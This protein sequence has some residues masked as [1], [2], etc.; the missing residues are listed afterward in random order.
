L[1]LPK[2]HIIN[3]R[4]VEIFEQCGIGDR[5]RALGSKHEYMSQVAWMTSLA[6]PT[7][8]HGR[9]LARSDSWGGGEDLPA[10]LAASPFTHTNLPQIRLEPILHERARELAPDDILIEH[11]LDQ[12]EQQ[13]G[14]V[15]ATVTDLKTGDP[16]QVV[17]DYVVAA[18]GGRTIGRI[19]GIEDVGQTNLV[20]MIT[21]YLRSPGIPQVNPDPRVSI[22]WFINPDHGG[23]IGSGVLVKMG[24]QGWGADADEWAF[25]FATAPDDE[26]EYGPDH[27]IG[28]IQ[29]AIG[30]PDLEVEVRRMSEWQIESIVAERLG[31]E[32][33][34]LIGDAAHRHPPTGGL[35]LN[36]AVQD[37]HNIAWKL[38]MVLSGQA[39]D[40]L[41]STYDG[42]R[43]PVAA[44]NAEQSLTS[45][46]QHAELDNAIGINPEDPEGG[47]AAIRTLF[48]AGDEGDAMRG[49]VATAVRGKRREFCALNLELGY[50]YEDGALIPDGTSPAP[51]G[52][53]VT[54]FRP[55][56]RPGHRMPH[57]W[58]ERDGNRISTYELAEYGR[59]TLFAGTEGDWRA[60]AD[61]VSAVLSVPVDVHVI[62]EGGDLDDPDGTWQEQSDVT[63]GGAVL[64]RPDQH[65]A[66]RM[67]E[68]PA[69]PIAALTEA[70]HTVLARGAVIAA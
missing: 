39:G 19:L 43:R 6:G 3:P 47:W 37:A 35:G 57:A 11:E 2:A 33:V 46:F 63:D 45:F 25:S 64:V 9:E 54:D 58:L 53:D 62:G 20:R 14:N 27:A 18:D 66:W 32:R 13:D 68:T 16:I 15:V 8:L 61:Q 30:V 29:A 51:R 38:A 48:A 50:S 60:A 55:S 5:V 4:T 28:R 24:G 10:S 40:G 65:V 23:S 22:Y 41:L 36:A 26:T 59:F 69:D 70:L 67:R 49:R 31:T 44:R 21:T 34:F 12:L 42:E 17:A 7:D 52:D 56:A 1:G